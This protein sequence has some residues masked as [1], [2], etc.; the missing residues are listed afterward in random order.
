MRLGLK[1]I[2]TVSALAALLIACAPKKQETA[3]VIRIERDGSEMVIIPGSIFA[4]GNDLTHPDFANQ[5][6]E[7]KALRPYHVLI[8]RAKKAWQMEAERPVRKVRV[9]RFAIDRHEV[10]N[11]QY[12]LFLD[13]VQ[14]NGDDSVRHEDQPV[15]KDHT[16][17]YWTSYNPLLQDEATA[18][19][20][21]FSSETFLKDNMPVVG[22]D[23]FDAYAYAKWAGK[24]LPTEAEWELAARGDDERLWPWG[25]SWSWGLCNIGGDK[26]GKDARDKSPDRDGYIYPAPVGSFA[27]SA[28]PFGC[29]D[30]AGNV[31]EWCAD[32]YSEDAYKV[33]PDRNPI[34]TIDSGYR[35]IRGGSSQSV[36]SGVRCSARSFEEP[37]FRKFTLGFRCAKD[38]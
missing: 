19:L 20:A 30:M 31:A 5:A 29:M 13:W 11:R 27:D 10:T 17:R 35:S 9:D 33:F 25:N 16:P 34:G 23:W 12:R 22:V 26:S 36:P 15:G 2:L 6:V 18:A 32:W 3:E 1:T 4:M 21:P 37:E 8:A 14:L 24:R 28:S 7:G 38:I